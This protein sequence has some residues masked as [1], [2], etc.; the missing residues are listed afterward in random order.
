MSVSGSSASCLYAPELVHGREAIERCIRED[1]EAADIVDLLNSGVSGR[2]SDTGEFVA[3]PAIPFPAV[4]RARLQN[5]QSNYAMGL[6]PAISRAWVSVDNR[7]TLWNYM[8]HQRQIAEYDG[9]EHAVTHVALVP[10]RPG[11]FTP[12]IKHLLVVSTAVDVRFLAVRFREP[13]NPA[14][15][16]TLIA[17][18]YRVALDR[19][20]VTSVVGTRG[21]RVFLTGSDGDLHE[22]SYSQNAGIF[23]KSC[24]K[25]N[26]SAPFLLSLLPKIPFVG[27]KAGV[28]VAVDDERGILY[29]LRAPGIIT[30][31]FL[32]E[33]RQ[34]TTRICTYKTLKRDALAWMRHTSEA[35]L[36]IVALFPVPAAE[37]SKGHLCAVSSSGVR[38]FFTTA[39][40]ASSHLGA[41]G[42]PDSR[43]LVETKA[44][45]QRRVVPSKLRMLGVRTLPSTFTDTS[46]NTVSVCAPLVSHD[47]SLMAVGSA[48]SHYS[49]IVCIARDAAPAP[50]V[51]GASTVYASPVGDTVGHLL[52]SH[53]GTDAGRTFSERVSVLPLPSAAVCSSEIPLSLLMSVS[54]APASLPSDA[55]SWA[56][57]GALLPP[58]Q[59]HVL[60]QE[61]LHPFV[62]QGPADV[63]AQAFER[64]PSGDPF[65]PG[66]LYDLLSRIGPA[67]LACSALSLIVRQ[68]DAASALLSPSA[69]ALSPR[70]PRQ[71]IGASVRPTLV[72][73]ATNLFV[74]LNTSALAPE[75]LAGDFTPALAGTA[76]F[77]ARLLSPFWALAALQ[78]NDGA[79]RNKVP[80]APTFSAR[81]MKNHAD[82]LERLLR[83]LEELDV[84]SDRRGYGMSVS[85][86][87][88]GVFGFSGLEESAASQT[89][90]AQATEANATPR[91]P[92]R[93]AVFGSLMSLLTRAIQAL[94]LIAVFVEIIPRTVLATLPKTLRAELSQRALG[95]LVSSFQGADTLRSAIHALSDFV[96][97]SGPTSSA[98]LTDRLARE[99]PLFYTEG[100]RFRI[101][102]LR[103]LA[104]AAGR[105][106]SVSERYEAAREA[107]SL[108]STHEGTLRVLPPITAAF[109]DIGAPELAVHAALLGLRSRAM[110]FEKLNSGERE[111]LLAD[112]A[113]V[114]GIVRQYGCV[115]EGE[116]KQ[117]RRLLGD[118]IDASGLTAKP[119]FA[120]V[121]DRAVDTLNAP[122][123]HNF[124][125]TQLAEGGND[126]RRFL[127]SIRSEFI[128][129]FLRSDP[130]RALL[131]ARWLSQNERFGSACTVL[132][133]HALSAP[134]MPLDERIGLLGEAASAMRKASRE[135]AEEFGVP[136][137]ILKRDADDRVEIAT[138]QQDLLSAVRAELSFVENDSSRH[139]A[140]LDAERSLAGEVFTLGDLYESF[141]VPLGLV[142]EQLC[143]LYSASEPNEA[144]AGD[145]WAQAL[146]PY[147]DA[148]AAVSA[149]TAV[150][151]RTT[152][153]LERL[154]QSG[155]ENSLRPLAA[156]L[157]AAAVDLGWAPGAA[158]E[159]L[160]AACAI[161]GALPSHPHFHALVSAFH[162]VLSGSVEAAQAAMR[163]EAA[164]SLHRLLTAWFDAV[165]SAAATQEMRANFVQSNFVEAAHAVISA[166]DDPT[167]SAARAPRAAAALAELRE[168]VA[169]FQ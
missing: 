161:G 45:W 39:P 41:M 57:W 3:R 99:C 67:E 143:L 145:L 156:S 166:L 158:G 62:R 136:L 92:P 110:R 152:H 102:A 109:C 146:A 94:R 168:I 111:R 134:N 116:E 23:R 77:V 79:D 87:R 7:L 58:R 86:I 124:L 84:S 100:D 141:A 20:N 73:S 80:L 19:T 150:L 121:A 2:Y 46:A 162:A 29:H 90:T 56:F 112:F 105:E 8:E 88:S 42:A 74:R 48:G 81:E 69:S 96:A 27:G 38:Y 76:L 149:V 93:Y 125:Y 154:H 50:P 132:T 147:D 131:L 103:I 117:Q 151:R 165:S 9:I 127:A 70:S 139:R 54:A 12:D 65:R 71:Y 10:P 43:L 115:S 142:E 83:F 66:I 16:L 140:L 44:N 31:F 75:M 78:K 133:E 95:D 135:E 72:S 89:K 25:Q 159:E 59:F 34:A 60:T 119:Q 24:K 160:A 106:V 157:V 53:V 144:H 40:T 130:S 30:V 55:I 85:A 4:I 13:A 155:I 122:A 91:V 36:K 169:K 33:R 98:N 61:G 108:L 52:R 11:V 1:R 138:L 128:E 97:S 37:S 118:T 22:L 64:D 35:D 32:G 51:P 5:F 68:P 18:G 63:L 82:V 49:R 126:E 14:S 114:L 101:Q 120:R 47:V 167:T 129:P 21:G 28:H 164:V 137:E 15:P 6:L 113:H 26:R 104:R 107:L 17:T 163:V 153:A 148:R 123:W